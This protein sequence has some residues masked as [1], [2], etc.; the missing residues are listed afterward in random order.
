MRYNLTIVRMTI[1]KI[2]QII[3]AGKVMETRGPFDT[4]DDNVY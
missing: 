3:D 2:L 1:I 4:V